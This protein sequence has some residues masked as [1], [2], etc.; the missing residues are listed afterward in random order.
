MPIAAEPRRRALVVDA[1]AI[2]A[3]LIEPADKGMKVARHMDGHQVFAPH[4]LPFEVDNV[5]RRRRNAGLLSHSEVTLGQRTF[6]RL[7]VE[8]W[9]FEA[10]APGIRGHA[11]NLTS[12]DASYVAL[13]EQLN[14]AL[15]TSD[16]RLAEA[17]GVDCRIELV[18]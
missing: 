10:L 2:V 15:L 12:Y 18:T 7:P 17:P 5:L 16:A 8:L 14:C 13:A 1:S 6:D 4:M 3:L 11:S 9:P